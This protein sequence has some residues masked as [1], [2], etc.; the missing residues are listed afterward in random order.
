MTLDYIIAAAILIIVTLW[1]LLVIGPFG[2]RP[3]IKT[4][5]V[6]GGRCWLVEISQG[7]VEITIPF[8]DFLLLS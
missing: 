6:W 2:V 4:R 1:T 3:M 8:D 7:D 5:M